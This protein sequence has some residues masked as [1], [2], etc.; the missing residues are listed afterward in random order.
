MKYLIEENRLRLLLEERRDYISAWRAGGSVLTGVSLV[1]SGLSS[2]FPDQSEKFGVYVRALLVAAGVLLIIYGL[3]VGIRNKGLFYNHEKLYE[4]VS[5]LDLT[6]HRFSIVVIKDT[7]NND[8]NHYLLRYNK[9]WDCYLFFSFRTQET[10]NEGNIKKK[11]SNA[12]HVDISSINLTYIA[13]EYNTKYSV[14]DKVTKT[15]DHKYYVAELATFPRILKNNKFC[16]DG[17]KYKWMTYPAMQKDKDIV[18]KN[19]DIVQYVT[20]H[21]A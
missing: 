16:I 18:E 7:Y 8:P 5:A 15:Y 10:N 19:M 9:D 21:V 3:V 13:D 20:Q 14:K 12:L 2:E 11:L 1:F 6:N 4:E 17:V